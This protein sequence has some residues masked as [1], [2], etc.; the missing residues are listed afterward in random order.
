MRRQD[1]RGGWASPHHPAEARSQ[2]FLAEVALASGCGAHRARRGAVVLGDLA[3]G[4]PAEGAA[5]AQEAIAEYAQRVR[6]DA[7]T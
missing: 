4:E 2:F 6:P 5:H 1:G 7:G 3:I